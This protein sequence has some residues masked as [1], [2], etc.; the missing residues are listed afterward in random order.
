MTPE[1][2]SKLSAT[3]EKLRERLLNDFHNAADSFYRFSMPIGKAD[4]N[5]LVNV[6]R[7]RLEAWLDEQARSESRGKKETHS[8]AR[9]RHYQ[10]AVK[11]AAATFLNR[12]VVI[13]YMEAIGLIRPA[14]VTGGLM[15]SGYREF[16]EFAPALLK[17]ETEG[18]ETLLKLLFNELAVDLPGLF[19]DMGI[20]ELFPV[21]AVTIRAVIEA[22]DDKDL[23]SVWAD[24]TTC[25]WVYQFW[26]DKER[27][28]LDQKVANQ[29][30]IEKHEIAAKT[31]LFTERYMVEW[32]LQ[33]SLNNQWLA[34]CEKNG[35]TCRAQSDGT[36]AA[37]EKRRQEW[38]TKRN[39][40]EIPPEAIMPIESDQEQKWKYWVKQPLPEAFID[41]VPDSITELKIL[42]PAVGSGHFLILA[43]DLLI[44]FYREEAHHKKE[45]WTDRQIA[46]QIIENNLHGVDLDPRAVQI[47]AAALMIKAKSFCKTASPK[48]INL[49]AS[50]L[51]LAS[52]PDDDPAIYELKQEV[53][54]ATGIPE[55]LTEKILHAL[56][57]ADHLGSLLKVDECVD[58]AIREHERIGGLKRTDPHSPHIQR[59]L[60]ET[61]Q[62]EQTLLTFDQAKVSFLEQL[63][64]FL[65][66]CTSGH[67]LGLRMRGEQLAAGV[68]FIR[69][70]KQGQ[71]DLVVANP[72]YLGGG[73]IADKQYIDAYYPEGKADLYAVFL[74][75]GIELTKSFGLSAMVT[76]RGWM[77][78]KD[79]ENLRYYIEDQKYLYSIADLHFGAFPEMRDVSVAMCII[80]N[81]SQNDR[82]T[83]FLQPVKYKLIVRDVKQIFRN[84]SGLIAPY[85]YYICLLKTF[86]AIQG[87]PFIYWWD[88]E[89]V[90]QYEKTPK[91]G[92]ETEVRQGMATSNNPRFLRFF[93]EVI[94]LDI[95]AQLFNSTIESLKDIKWVPYIK[96]AVGR[97]WFDTF[98]TIIN[99]SRNGLEHKV[100]HEIK[101]SSY[102][103]RI[104]SE[105][106]FFRQ[107][108][109]YSTIGS[110]FLARLM[111]FQSIFDVSGSAVFPI[112]VF[113]TVCL[114]NSEI[115]TKVITALNPTI[116]FQVGDINR[117]ALFNI[118]SSDIIFGELDETFSEQEEA[119]ETSIE[120]KQPGPS[121]WKYAQKWAQKSVNRPNGSP[122]LEYNPNYE[123]P[124]KTV[125]LSY[126]IGIV[127][128][129]FGASGEGILNIAP[130]TA[131]PAGI[132]YLSARS[133]KDSLRHPACQG[134]KSSWEEN[135]SDIAAGV[136]LKKWL[137][138]SFFTDVHLDMYEKRPIYF[139]LSSQKK[140]FVAY[141]SIHRW[142]DDTLKTLLA[143]YLIP[144]LNQ[145]DGEMKDL[146]ESR[147]KGDKKSQ[148]NSENRFVEAK[149]FYDELTE[150][151]NIVRQCAEQGPP[152][153]KPIDPPRETSAHFK[154]DLDDGVMINSAALWPLLEPQWKQP[155][156]WWSELCVA[157]GRKDYDW[158]HL[159]ARYFPKRLDDKCKKDPSLA[160]AHGCFWKFH[161]EKAYQW[162][163]RLKDEIALDFTIDEKDS[164]QL[165]ADFEK[166][167]P[168]IV[169]KLVK[170]ELKRRKK[171]Y[172]ND[173]DP[174]DKQQDNLSLP[175]ADGGESS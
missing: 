131:L 120:F 144:E 115:T 9:G 69:L 74:K 145:I 34:I 147:K 106:F 103:K 148:T 132:L 172:K 122:L 50:N 146:L 73:K 98:S 119:R 84:I 27:E 82:E 87:H 15:S 92:D 171:K 37:L 53:E 58:E 62:P 79:Y 162:E 81:T 47:A 95:T 89:F 78:I 170:N 140:N 100:F 94:N 45:T 13:R 21:P 159:T 118:E 67:D 117:L 76:M 72:P 56:K 163:L 66:K 125:Y 83:L 116:N 90:Q 133:D 16:R 130:D 22:F 40:G 31:Q 41:S 61:R 111:R 49:V 6:K 126:A 19:G 136:T 123:E 57:G 139:P 167:N 32:L 166:E 51:G 26:N 143:E 3:I 153:A 142:A 164:D 112:D 75:R 25:G 33:N 127:L 149:S 59:K 38:R 141:I 134:L 28:A 52:L 97:K 152:P 20:S 154:M 7:Q 175:F 101:Y 12:I 160:V 88:E 64:K 17:D 43:F 93:W 65:D 96:G 44:N 63:D 105:S 14:V 23:D 36:L 128:G 168:K 138:H 4:L 113:N 60:W 151:I 91:L 86:K 158:A 1:A 102:S 104:P 46:E 108:I 80:A 8:Q 124:N 10:T 161:P 169:K 54:L 39:S 129:R 99:W 55:D 48:I 173:S 68:R 121:A 24:D 2:K 109:S 156:T 155:R 150:F 77:F 5:E 114:M 85:G 18:F 107:G 137:M 71:Y 30:K 42:D 157:K 35:W 70:V 165:R 29:G 110:T 135:G 174:F 11:L